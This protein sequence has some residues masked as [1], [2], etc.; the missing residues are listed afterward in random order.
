MSKTALTQTQKDGIMAA[1]VILKKIFPEDNLQI[2]FNIAQ[3]HDNVNYNFKMSGILHPA[4][5]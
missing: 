3:Q 2:C 5:T 1:G 4:K